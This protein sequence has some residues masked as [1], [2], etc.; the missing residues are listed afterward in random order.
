MNGAPVGE[1]RKLDFSRTGNGVAKMRF[2]A[3]ARGQTSCNFGFRVDNPT[4]RLSGSITPQIR[5]GVSAGYRSFSKTF[6]SDW[7]PLNPFTVDLPDI[8]LSGHSGTRHEYTYNGG[9]RTFIKKKPGKIG[10]NN[11]GGDRDLD[12]PTQG[13]IVYL[14]SSQ[15]G[16]KIRRTVGSG[17]WLAAVSKA[18]GIP[19]KF[20][21]FKLADGAVLLKSSQNGKFVNPEKDPNGL[22]CASVLKAKDA[23]KFRIIPQRDGTVALYS[24]SR[25]RYVRA[26]IGPSTLLGAASKSVSTWEKFRL[27]YVKAKTLPRYIKPAPKQPRIIVPPRG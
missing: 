21:L 17:R 6:R 19:E 20:E 10:S 11:N 4:Y 1:R 23:E 24:P 13:E 25:R 22:L 16:L 12:L 2:P 5:F 18:A 3:M 14:T 7:I 27:Q 15:N 9:T 8:H 26:G